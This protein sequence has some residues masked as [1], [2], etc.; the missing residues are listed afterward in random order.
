MLNLVILLKLVPPPCSVQ[1]W[2]QVTLRRPAQACTVPKG[3]FWPLVTEEGSGQSRGRRRVKK[4]SRKLVVY[5][6]LR[7]REHFLLWID[8]RM[9]SWYGYSCGISERGCCGK[10]K[11]AAFINQWKVDVSDGQSWF[12]HDVGHR[13]LSWL[14]TSISWDCG[15]GAECGYDPLRA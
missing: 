15:V 10:W 2:R 12:W 1:F 8:E 11:C 9:L 4:Q 3:H 6:H 5:S 7:S 13:E 14:E